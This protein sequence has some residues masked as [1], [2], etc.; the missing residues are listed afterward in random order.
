VVKEIVPAIVSERV[1]GFHVD[2]NSRKETALIRPII[3]E[4]YFAKERGAVKDSGLGVI[5][6][7]FSDLLFETSKGYGKVK[8]VFD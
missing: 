6:P 5:N 1:L 8:S 3:S 7:G 2:L 4:S